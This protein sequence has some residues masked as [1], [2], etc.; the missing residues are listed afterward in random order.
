MPAVQRV[1][2]TDQQK[3]RPVPE[4]MLVRTFFGVIFGYIMSD[5]I[6]GS[7][8]PDEFREDAAQYFVDIYL[9]G[10]LTGE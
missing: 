6:L 1:L 7:K 10:I 4:M 3:L 9:H 5:I 8:A 2:Q